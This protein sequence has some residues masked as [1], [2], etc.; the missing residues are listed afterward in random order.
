MI[1]ISTVLV[2]LG[3]MAL[4]LKVMT[5]QKRTAPAVTTPAFARKTK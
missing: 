1:L 2:T 3:L 4:A 5:P